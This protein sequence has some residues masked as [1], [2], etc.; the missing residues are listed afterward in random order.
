MDAVKRKEQ[1]G[2]RA[3]RPIMN[4]NLP[5]LRRKRSVSSIALFL[6]LLAIALVCLY[7][8]EARRLSDGFHS[9]ISGWFREAGRKIPPVQPAEPTHA[10]ALSKTDEELLEW[11]AVEERVLATKV[12]EYCGKTGIL[13]GEIALIRPSAG[14]AR[15]SYPFE[16]E[17]S[18]DPWGTPYRLA[19][20]AASGKFLMI[21]GG[22]TKT[23]NLDA[24]ITKSLFASMKGQVFQDGG[25]VVLVG[26]CEF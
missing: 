9:L 16:R 7:E 18:I 2:A 5:L 20:D 3:T 12:V 11:A 1:E 19:P 22:P 23:T 14:F 24:S 6:A 21:S 10:I 25:R 13:P 26:D 15:S 4:S 8:W 17:I